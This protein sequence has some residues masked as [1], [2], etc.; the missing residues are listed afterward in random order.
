MPLYDIAL[1]GEPTDEQVGE[2]SSL[3]SR[4]VQA[5]GLEVGREVNWSVRP[6]DFDPPQRNAAVAAFFGTPG[7]SDAGIAKVLSRGIPIIPVVSKLGRV[8]DDLPKKL[9]AINSLEY[10]PNRPERVSTA[11]LECIGLLPGQRRTFLSY[12]RNEARGAALQLFDTLSARQFDVFLDTHGVAP[13]EDFQQVLWHRLCDSDVLIM[14]DTPTFFESRWTAA[15]FGRALAK[16]ISVLRV[17]WPGVTPHA[18][19]TTASRLDLAAD[20]LDPAT[21][22]LSDDAVDRICIQVEEVRSLSQAVRNLNMYTTLKLAV[23]KIGGTV[24]AVGAQRSIYITLPDKQAIV[25][26]PTV[27]VPTSV[28]MHDAIRRS[29]DKLPSAVLYDPVG[30]HPDWINHI[31]WLGANISSPRWIRSHA[32]AWELADW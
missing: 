19:V 21:G 32:A 11:L 14:L 23:E 12:R 7:A 6:V 10:E 5:F 16:N 18:R 25:L 8:S 2:V 1:M 26:Y 13:G 3:V 27:C 9:Q 15:E 24:D 20:D 30:L 22:T 17:G 4:L 31:D 29:E 28:T